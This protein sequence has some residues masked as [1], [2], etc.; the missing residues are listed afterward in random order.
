[1]PTCQPL[2]FA[3][4]SEL[5]IKRLTRFTPFGQSKLAAEQ[6]NFA[7]R[8]IPYQTRAA[9]AHKE[10]HHLRKAPAAPYRSRSWDELLKK[11]L[12]IGG[13]EHFPEFDIKEARKLESAFGRRAGFAARMRVE[14][15]V[16]A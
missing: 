11:L 3:V 5:P 15:P 7:G 10:G 8:S 16:N 14:P 13:G 4:V 6:A 9:K 12:C 2:A 1:M